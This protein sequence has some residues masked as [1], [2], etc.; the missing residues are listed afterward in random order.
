MSRGRFLTVAYYGAIALLL[1]LIL[2]ATLA[3]VLPGG[4]AGQVSRNSEG[5]LVLLAVSVWIQF[6]RVRLVTPA[7]VWSTALLAAAVCVVVGLVLRYGPVPP[8][9]VTLNEPAFALALLLPY[10]QLRRPLPPWGWLLPAAAVAI[11]LVGGN[12]SATTDLAEA[13]GALFLIPISVDAIDRGILDRSPVPLLRVLAWMTVLVVAVVALHAVVDRT[14]VGVVEEVTRYISRVTEMF[15]A[16]LL[17]HTYFSLL[18]PE[19]RSQQPR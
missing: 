4:L 8:Q 5:L 6:V 10:L 18:R 2:T 1:T 14:P 17:F 3:R 13:F 11:P 7:R 15:I 12:N 19:L 9:L 16:S